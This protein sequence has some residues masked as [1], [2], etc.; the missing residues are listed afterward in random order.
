MEEHRFEQHYEKVH[1]SSELNK[2]RRT[3]CCFDDQRLTG[4][5]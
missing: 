2:D 1:F 3:E 4:P 5:T